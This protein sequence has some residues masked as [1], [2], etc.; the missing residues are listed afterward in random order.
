MLRRSTI[1]ALIAG[2]RFRKTDALKKGSL[3]VPA[4]Y[5][6][7][8]H[9]VWTFPKCLTCNRDVDAVSIK[10]I[11]RNRFEYWASCHG[12]EDYASYDIP[13]D[14]A[15]APDVRDEFGY[16]PKW[17]FIRQATKG[18]DFFSPAHHEQASHK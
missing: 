1:D 5:V 18:V 11:S 13:E 4:G 12:A 7:G 10:D 9:S 6:G 16:T 15:E 17:R 14:V 8:S 3:Y 2:T